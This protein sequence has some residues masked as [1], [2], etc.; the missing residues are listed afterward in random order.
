MLSMPSSAKNSIGTGTWW[1][2]LKPFS[3]PEKVSK[4]DLNVSAKALTL[5]SPLSPIEFF[6]PDWSSCS[7]VY[8]FLMF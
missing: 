3:K 1:A 2:D 7:M 4:L 8:F 5:I 6:A